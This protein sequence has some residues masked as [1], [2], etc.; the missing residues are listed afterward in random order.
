MPLPMPHAPMPPPM[1]HAPHA[2]CP[3]CHMPPMPHASDAPHGPH[4]P[5]PS[6]KKVLQ[7]IPPT[8]RNIFSDQFS[9]HVSQGYG[10]YDQHPP[11]IAQKPNYR[12]SLAATAAL[13]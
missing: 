8:F 13:A 1:P 9:V 12:L 2:K 6:P 7:N 11:S 4:A 5:P 3:P 10:L